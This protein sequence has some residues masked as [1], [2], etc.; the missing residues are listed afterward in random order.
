MA[1]PQITPAMRLCHHCT[2]IPQLVLCLCRR[3]TG[4]LQPCFAFVPEFYRRIF[5][6]ITHVCMPH[7]VWAGLKHVRVIVGRIFREI[8][9]GLC[10]NYASI[11]HYRKIIVP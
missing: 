9:T 8:T 6:C 1:Q 11:F 4:I 5:I 2:P 10:R 3:C 7:I